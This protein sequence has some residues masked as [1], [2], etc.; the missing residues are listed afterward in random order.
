MVNS[1]TS[2][3][4]RSHLSRT[5]ALGKR[6]ARPG[7]A[8]TLVELLVV[9]AIISLLVT[10]LMPAL[11]RAMDVAKKVMCHQTLRNIG[12]AVTLYEAENDQVMMLSVDDRREDGKFTLEEEEEGESWYGAYCWP[13]TL[14]DG[15]FLDE[16][17]L[18]CPANPDRSDKLVDYGMNMWSMR[19]YRTNDDTLTGST[20][21]LESY[22]LEELSELE[23]RIIFAESGIWKNDP[24]T[25]FNPGNIHRVDTYGNTVRYLHNDETECAMMFGDKH[26]G[27]VPQTHPAVHYRSIGADSRYWLFDEKAGAIPMTGF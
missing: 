24:Q 1:T 18:M 15:R 14:V 21:A 26:I 8:F 20:W 11:G 13:D 7:A 23:G 16:G 27:F 25:P 19:G 22:K 3:P 17:S 10:I 5:S 6:Q 9:V 2:L 4:A 12:T